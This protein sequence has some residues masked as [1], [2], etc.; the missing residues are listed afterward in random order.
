VRNLLI[1]A[2]EDFMNLIKNPMWIFYAT[3][4][5][6]LMVVILGFLTKDNYGKEI[7]SY[8]YYGITLILYSLLSCGMTS[9][10]AFMEE[11]IKKP[12]MRIIYA[13]GRVSSIFF[14]KIIATFVFSSIMHLFDMVLLCLVFSIHLAAIP[15]MILL[16]SLVE[17]FSITLGIMLCCIF[18]TEGMTN[19]ILSLVVFLISIFGGLLF[20]MDG[21]GEVVRKICSL[22]PAKWFSNTAFQMIYDNNY[23]TLL[24]TVILLTVTIVVMIIIS[25]LTFRKEDCIC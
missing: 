25:L 20:S 18:K 17:L 6:I 14:S 11:R 3:V 8:D 5:P 9:A 21:Y 2:R 1:I 16:F 24:P 13:P 4:F 22:S 12:N 23:S 7:G 10:N 19:Q 15:Q